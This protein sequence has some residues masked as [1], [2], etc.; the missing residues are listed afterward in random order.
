MRC[1]RCPE[2]LA[3]PRCNRPCECEAPALRPCKQCRLAK[4]DGEKAPEGAERAAPSR[5]LRQV[6]PDGQVGR[7]ALSSLFYQVEASGKYI[8]SVL[9]DW[10]QAF[11]SCADKQ[12]AAVGAL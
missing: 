4:V 12:N 5:R 8:L 3:L 2:N 9:M 10:R 7:G 11:L 1:L 6:A